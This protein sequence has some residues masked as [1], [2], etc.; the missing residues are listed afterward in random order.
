MKG[1]RASTGRSGPVRCAIYTRTSSTLSWDRDTAEAQRSRCEQYIHG[2]AAGWQ[3]LPNRYDDGPEQSGQRLDRPAFLRLVEDI[4]RR[5]VDVV[6]VDRLDRLAESTLLIG[7]LMAVFVERGIP[8]LSVRKEP[9]PLKRA[10]RELLEEIGLDI[11][12]EDL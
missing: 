8:I 2:S 9:E 6:V 1:R 11:D 10:K 7:C 5:R 3:V 4:R 12:E